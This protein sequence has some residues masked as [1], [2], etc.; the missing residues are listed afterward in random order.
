MGVNRLSSRDPNYGPEGRSFG[1]SRR[2]GFARS[3][4]SSAGDGSTIGGEAFR[5][6]KNNPMS[7]STL[8]KI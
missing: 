6:Y 7:T 2:G 1:D 5:V 8:K 4:S 3:K